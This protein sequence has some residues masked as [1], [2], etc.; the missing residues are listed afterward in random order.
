MVLTLLTDMQIYLYI[1]YFIFILS[2]FSII[3]FHT[4]NMHTAAVMPWYR[5]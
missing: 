2:S 5:S 4:T 1:P 3:G